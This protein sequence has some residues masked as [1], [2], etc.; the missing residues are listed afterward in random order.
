[1]RPRSLLVLLLAAIV[2]ASLQSAF[3]DDPAGLVVGLQGEVRAISGA[4]ASRVLKLRAPVYLKDTIRTGAG[5]KL[6]VMFK[7]DSLFSQGENTEIVID[8]F[9]YNPDRA[10]E[11]GM[12]LKIAKGLARI[13]TGRI[14][15]LNPERFKVKTS[16]ATIGIRGCELGFLCGG[17]ADQ[18]FVVRVPVGRL[19]RITPNAVDSFTDLRGPGW[20]KIWDDGRTQSGSLT[21]DDMQMISGGTTP[22][23]FQ[24][25]KRSSEPGQDAESEDDAGKSGGG[26]GQDSE[27]DGS[28]A[29]TGEDAD[30]SGAGDETGDVAGTQTDTTYTDSGVDSLREDVLADSTDPGSELEPVPVVPP[31]QPAPKPLRGGGL[32]GVYITDTASAYRLYDVYVYNKVS[33]TLGGGFTSVDISGGRFDPAGNYLGPASVSFRSLPLSVFGGRERYEGWQERALEPGV[34]LANDNLQEFVV[35]KDF[36]VASQRLLYWGRPASDFTGSALPPGAVV[37]YDV[38]L[39]MYPLRTTEQPGANSF[40]GDGTLRVNTRTGGFVVYKP[41]GK[42]TFGRIEELQFFGRDSQGVGASALTPPTASGSL[43]GDAAHALAGFRQPGS[44]TPAQTGAWNR[45]GYAAS[46]GIPIDFTATQYRDLHSAVLSSD[47]PMQAEGR[48]TMQLNRDAL[49]NNVNFVLRMSQ[50][51]GS[52]SP[53]DL[54][55]NNPSRSTFVEGNSFGAVV[56]NASV[57]ADLYGAGGGQNWTWGEW[58]GEQT[59]ES[60]GSPAQEE[61]HGHYVVGDTLSPA[62]FQ[63]LVFG[64]V[65][66]NLSTPSGQPGHMA[67]T[68]TAGNY[69]SKVHGTAMLNVNI[70]GSGMSPTWSGVFN[71]G[72]G[73]NGDS[74]NI[75]YTGPYIITP[76][77]HL[78]AGTPNNYQVNA[79]GVNYTMSQLS[80]AQITG[81]L[82]GPGSGQRPVTGAIGSGRFPHLD[83]SVVNITY[84]TDL[85]T[86]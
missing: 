83:G 23:A 66:Y 8:E 5:A 77:G 11:N 34:R 32:G 52:V 6:Q 50:N 82:V 49:Q 59:V 70:P 37:G 80:G 31:P 4:G 33:G 67:A 84:G 35:R 36:N 27:G 25:Q 28:S 68:I 43:Q 15:D 74:V 85:V 60:L 51:P 53:N 45:R 17:E 71:A 24:P 44:A 62:A 38:T 20:L 48:V 61:T 76:N 73:A 58:D 42:P 41:D 56:D 29:A 75:I 54:A 26:S 72:P 10:A 40:I 69:F 3:A 47:D 2:A 39:L 63:A 64:S 78:Q 65:G 19:I 55:L 1:M 7:D 12:G 16:R 14:T 18:V 79:N 81:S 21:E 86:P 22:E 9:V 13:V 46:V 30:D 57:R